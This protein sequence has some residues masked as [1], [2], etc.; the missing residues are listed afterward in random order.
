VRIKK[1]DLFYIKAGT[2]HAIGAGALIAEIQE[3]SNLTYRL[4]DY[5]RIDKNGNKR[6][7]HID[8]ALEVANLKASTEP[9]QPMRV[10]KY[11]Q[12]CA[13][14][15]L[16]RCE[17]FEVNRMIVN[18]ERCRQ[19]VEYQAD[20]TSFRVLLCTDGCGSIHFG[21]GEYLSFFK[22]DCIFAPANS[23]AI[24]IHG[25]AQFLDVRG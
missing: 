20:S 2:I 8:K 24:K 11:R 13:T 1:D 21:N 16:C 9:R 14:E 18:T 3:N 5:D 10:L 15:L 17:Y 7:L 4:Y 25:K 19:M 23:V 22:G 12:G 6:E